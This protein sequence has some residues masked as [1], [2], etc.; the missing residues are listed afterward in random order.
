MKKYIF[1]LSLFWAT[2]LT[3]AQNITHL[4]Y[5]ID[6]FVA[7]GKGT[8]LE[9]PGNSNE[10]NSDFNIDISSLEPGTHTIHFRSMNEDGIWSFAA[11]R[12]FYIPE[13]PIE[14]GI[15]A[16]EYSID[17]YVKEG[18]GEPLI[19]QKGTNS[20][21]SVL[22]IDISDLE[23]GIHNINMRSKNKLGVWS[24][25]VSKSFV[26]VK[27]DTTKIENIV[28]RFYNDSYKGTWMTSAV[29]PARKDVDSI[30]MVSTTGLDLD[31]DY[32]IE[33]YAKNNMEVRS[34]ST[35]LSNVDLQINNSPE[36]LKD[37]LQLT[38]SSSQQMDVQMDSLFSDADLVIGDRLMYALEGMDAMNVQ[39][40][41]DW[42]SV[43]LLSFMPSAEYSG[44][45]YF[46]LKTTDVAGESDSVYVDLT[47]RNATGINSQMDQN[48]FI[49]YPNPAHELLTIKNMNSTNSDFN[50]KLY[51]SDG[52]LL[53]V[54]NVYESVYT[55]SLGD[56][57]QGIYVIYLVNNKFTVKKKIIK[58]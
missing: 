21:D 17:A 50:L 25:P 12:A 18:E 9:I 30:F 26:I 57:P 34:F 40:F 3:S 41:T 19:L 39:N 29:D 46:W 55:L 44:M 10:L 16:M 2:T 52:R 28:Y 43:D 5:S 31:Q 36:R 56:Y 51:T 33:F 14:D 7:E 58:R 48:A 53:L 22:N 45:Y 4:E 11:E 49:V 54:K 47:I 15:V 1:L 13:P 37:T 20:V 42:S 38:I 23:A 27:P 35:F 6:G 8:A 32:T 24:L